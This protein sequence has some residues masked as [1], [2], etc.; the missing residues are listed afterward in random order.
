MNATASTHAGKNMR[1]ACF[2]PQRAGSRPQAAARVQ[3]A[4]LVFLRAYSRSR[5]KILSRSTQMKLVEFYCPIS[6]NKE[7]VKYV[8]LG[9]ACDLRH[10]VK[11]ESNKLLRI[12]YL[13]A[14]CNTKVYEL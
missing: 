14:Y 7:N 12:P 9:A 1:P 4:S 8:Q 2:G 13:W 6:G 5:S 11:Y 3:Q 10:A